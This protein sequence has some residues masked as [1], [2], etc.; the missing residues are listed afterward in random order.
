MLQGVDN[1]TFQA[2]ADLAYRTFLEQLRAAGREVVPVEQ[3]QPFFAQLQLAKGTPDAP[4]SKDGAVVFSPT[5]LPLW[6][7]NADPQWS[8]AGFSQANLR[9]FTGYSKE[10]DAFM[11]APVVV[12][13]FARMSSSGNHSSLVANTAEVGASMEMGVRQMFVHVAHA[14]EARNGL[15]FKGEEGDI[16]LKQ[17]FNSDVAFATMEKLEE[18]KSSGFMALLTGS[19]KS[20]SLQAANTDNARYASVASGLLTQATGA[21]AR[22]FQQHAQ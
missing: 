18:N 15:L 11:I 6:W 20:K 13:D 8:D 4:Y 7:H 22:F 16:R 12:V 14:T 19:G 21:L 17:G 10:I 5:A 3:L 1:A 9:A 2:L